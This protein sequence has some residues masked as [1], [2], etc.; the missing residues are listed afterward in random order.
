MRQ[1]L[2]NDQLTPA[3]PD[4]PATA[5][6]PGCG[7]P[8]DLRRREATWFW[9]HKTGAPKD[10]LAKRDKG[11]QPGGPSPN[12][13]PEQIAGLIALAQRIGV[14][15]VTLD[16]GQVLEVTGPGVIILAKRR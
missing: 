14:E 8:V 3:S 13:A 6:C 4:A 16:G 12:P 1:A 9:R 15:V 2:V 11:W 7:H 10:C 5:V